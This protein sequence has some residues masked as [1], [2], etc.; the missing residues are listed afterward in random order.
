M[1]VWREHAGQVALLLTDLVMPGGMGGQQLAR[2]LQEERP[3]LE[4]VFTSG[5]SGDIAG[6]E[7]S[8]RSGENF[9]QKPCTADQ[10]L[11][12]VRRSLDA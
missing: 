7:L 12:A 5:Y 11:A 1:R 8:L 3:G 4:V 10:L 9:L 2:Q 6:R